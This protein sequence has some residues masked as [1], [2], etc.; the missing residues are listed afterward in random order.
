MTNYIVLLV[1]YLAASISSMFLTSTPIEL[2]SL[3]GVAI[4]M[5]LSALTLVPLVDVLRSFTQ[6][7]SEKTGLPFKTAGTQML[8]LTFIVALLCVIFAGLP[9]QIFFGVLAA[10]TFG[11]LADV[12]VFRKMG[13]YFTNPVKRMAFS[14][15]AATLLGSGLVFFVAFSDLVFEASALTRPLNEVTVGWLAQSTFIWTAGLLIGVGIEWF[16]NLKSRAFKCNAAVIILGLVTVATLLLARPAQA[17]P[18]VWGNTYT[19]YTNQAGITGNPLETVKEHNATVGIEGGYIGESVT[20]YGFYEFNATLDNQFAKVT[21]HVKVVDNWTVYVQASQFYSQDFSETQR[22]AGLGYQGLSF[23]DLVFTPFVALNVTDSNFVKNEVKP[24]VGWTA[25]TVA[26]DF[27]ITHWNESRYDQ[28]NGLTA[29]GAF[30]VFYDL[31]DDMYVGAQYR[32][33]YNEAGVTGFGDA[34]IFRVGYHL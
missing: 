14:N 8:T 29:N 24:M 11:G 30:G 18:I 22:S 7:A 23:G 20:A 5:P 13:Q 26:D 17:E 27:L 25:M 31:P 33:F 2:F 28:K 15:A 34:L 4:W 19:D 9:H 21:T 3:A 1:A 32:Y 12:L 6:D 16:K 10:V